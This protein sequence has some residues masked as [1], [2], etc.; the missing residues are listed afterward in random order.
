MVNLYKT[1][2][3]FPFSVFRKR[4]FAVCPKKAVSD[5]LQLSAKNSKES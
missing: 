3:S 5:Q 1:V 4:P 2:F